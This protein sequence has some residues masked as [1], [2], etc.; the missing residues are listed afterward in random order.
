MSNPFTKLRSL[1]ARSKKTEKRK[2]GDKGEELCC[3]QLK[4]EGCTI[5]ARN[6][7]GGGGELDIVVREGNNL[8]VVEVKT[9][10]YYPQSKYGSPADAVDARKRRCILSAT[11]SYR[12][13]HSEFAA[14]PLRFDI[15]EVLLFEDGKS[16]INR[17]KGAFHT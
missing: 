3:K 4:K 9:R 14:M 7:T 1:F 17:I 2:I 8:V 13:S 12:K 11:K 10:H 6:Y 16:E 15:M 5:L